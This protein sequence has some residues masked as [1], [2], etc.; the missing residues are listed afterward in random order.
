MDADTATVP[1]TAT[2]DTHK[3]PTTTLIPATAPLA[4]KLDPAATPTEAAAVDTVGLLWDLEWEVAV[5]AWLEAAA[6]G[7]VPTTA[8]TEEVA[9]TANRVKTLK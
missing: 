7:V 6:T 3:P 4:P 8:H 5:T 1:A 2:A 9:T